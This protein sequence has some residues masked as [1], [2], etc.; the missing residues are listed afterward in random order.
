MTDS[1]S[2]GAPGVANGIPVEP[3]GQARTDDSK[4]SDAAGPAAGGAGR[5]PSTELNG[6]VE[7]AATRW[8]LNPRLLHA[9]IRVESNYDSGAVSPKGAIGLMQIMPDTGRRYG[10]TDPSALYDAATNIGV[11]SRH[12]AALTKRF[13]GDLR[14]VLAAYNAG[15]QAVVNAGYKVPGFVETRNYVRGVLDRYVQSGECDIGTDCR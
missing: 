7:R 11:G 5:I 13:D 1:S 14:L 8:G 6:L 2:Y 4:G 10:V 9:V 3:L 12:M 15:E